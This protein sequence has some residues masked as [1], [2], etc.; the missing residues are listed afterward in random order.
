VYA[1]G[2]TWLKILTGMTLGKTLV[3]GMYPFLPGDALK[4]AVAVPI[5]KAVR[6][7][8]KRK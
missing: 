2:L 4:I 7:V 8:I 3:V 6:P 1:C 5:I